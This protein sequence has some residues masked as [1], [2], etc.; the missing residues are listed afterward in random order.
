MQALQYEQS[1]LNISNIYKLRNAFLRQ[2]TSL[3]YIEGGL[4][5][6]ITQLTT[7]V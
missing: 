7:H 5:I 3:V 4:F 6:L 2:I 1:Y